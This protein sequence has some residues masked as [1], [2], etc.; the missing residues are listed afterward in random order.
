[1]VEHLIR[2]TVDSQPRQTRR[3]M[4][5]MDATRQHNVG[6]HS[7]AWITHILDTNIGRYYG[8][9]GPYQPL[10]HT[11]GTKTLRKLMQKL[12]KQ[13]TTHTVRKNAH[14]DNAYANTPRFHSELHDS[15]ELAPQLC[16]H[17]KHTLERCRAIHCICNTWLMKY[18]YCSLIAC[19]L[20]SGDNNEQPIDNLLKLLNTQSF[21]KGV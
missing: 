20:F 16:V 19:P 15:L 1:M 6:L 13:L 4:F 17:W 18:I 2:D 8:N 12:R 14:Y 3:L 5:N 9:M 7:R 10:A 21:I 11:M